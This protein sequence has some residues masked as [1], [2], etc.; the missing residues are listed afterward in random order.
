MNVCNVIHRGIS[1]NFISAAMSVSGQFGKLQITTGIQLTGKVLGRGSDATVLEVDW[2]GT[3]CAAKELHKVFPGDQSPGGAR[4][5]TT[6]FMKECRTWST[7]RHPQIVQFLGVY[8]KKGYQAPMLIL[9]KMDESLSDHLESHNREE[10]PVPAKIYVLRQVAQA[11]S[12]LHSRSPPLVHHDL[13]PNNVLLNEVSLQAK[14]TDFGMTRAMDPS[15]TSCSPLAV[16]KKRSFKSPKVIRKVIDDNEKQDVFAYGNVVITMVT[17]KWP[18][19]GPAT[20]RKGKKSIAVNEL[21]RRQQYLDLFTPKESELFLPIVGPC[22]QNDPTMRPTS[23]QLV[24][25]MEQIEKLHPKTGPNPQYISQLQQDRDLLQQAMT[26][27]EESLR[28]KNEQLAEKRTQLH[29]KE[30][31]LRKAVG[32]SGQKVKEIYDLQQIRGEHME[33][34]HQLRKGNDGHCQENQRLHLQLSVVRKQ[35]EK[36]EQRFTPLIQV[37]NKELLSSSC[38]CIEFNNTHS[39]VYLYTHLMCTQNAHV[40]SLVR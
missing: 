31:Q 39:Y 18:N 11:L 37:G 5:F 25:Q 4:H 19:P 30:S 32:E 38:T 3:L 6:S 33:K 12:Y 17:H 27:K 13:N 28:L 20:K 9:E 22:L 15:K 35:M 34:I 24:T 36:L 7:L 40:Q 2:N 14:V 16:E 8:L 26:S 23:I 1:L 29:E 21:E 10:F